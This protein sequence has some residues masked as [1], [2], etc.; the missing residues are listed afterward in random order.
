MPRLCDYACPR[1]ADYIFEAYRDDTEDMNS[2]VACPR[3]G[4]ESPRC[5][6]K[7]FPA[8]RVDLKAKAAH[9]NRKFAK[10]NG[11]YGLA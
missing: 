2:P 1:C 10:H 11:T 5:F 4:T 6:Y 8:T 3:C 9:V 7:K